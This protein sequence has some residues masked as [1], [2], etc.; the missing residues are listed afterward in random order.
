MTTVDDFRTSKRLEPTALIRSAD[1][2]LRGLVTSRW[3]LIAW[4]ALAITLA[5]AAP[6][7]FAPLV[8]PLVNG[9]ATPLLW[10]PVAL[11]VGWSALNLV[12]SK[13]IVELRRST[14]TLAGLHLFVDAAAMTLWFLMTGAATNPFTTLYFVPIT[15]ATQVSPRWTWVV[16]TC[17]LL[18]F[19]TLFA[20]T[21]MPS[22]HADHGGHFV[23]HLQGMWLAFGVSGLLVTI[24][25]HRIA[26]RLARQ[27]DELIRWRDAALEDRHLASLGSLAAGA[28]HE[29]GTPLGT[30]ALLAGELEYL[31]SAELHA[32]AESIRQEIVRCKA[33][34]HRMASPDARVDALGLGE[35]WP[36]T[37]LAEGHDLRGVA[38]RVH[39]SASARATELDQPYV[40][41]AQIIREL[42]SNAA[43][44]CRAKS[45]N[46]GVDLHLDVRGE[47]AYLELCDEGIG[48]TAELSSLAFDP[49]FSTKPAGSGLGLYLVRAQIRQLDGTIELHS[50]PSLGTRV[51]VKFPLRRTI[52]SQT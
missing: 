35:R 18:G 31:E 17:S 15:L 20:G 27:R 45:P 41:V 39:V 32:A 23:G 29:L 3:V 13:F 30:I 25:V 50:T 44:A 8:G 46:A 6:S 14:P 48:M 10:G 2:T 40:A 5:S 1:I 7:T 11:L 51:D 43:E 19:A 47:A 28:A 12:T 34:V 26:V 33:I 4:F 9:H 42:L 49:F 16:A 38:L 24:F 36:L 22:G 21:P 52:S 37:R